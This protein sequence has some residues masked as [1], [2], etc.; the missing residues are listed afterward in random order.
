MEVVILIDSKKLVGNY[1]EGAAQKPFFAYP[2]IP[3]FELGNLKRKE[4]WFCIHS[5]DPDLDIRNYQ[6]CDY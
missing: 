5:S 6:E 1:G 4:R 2:H 3:G